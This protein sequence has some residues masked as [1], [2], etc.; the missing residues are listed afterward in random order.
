[1]IRFPN[2]ASARFGNLR[3]QMALR[4]RS[5]GCCSNIAAKFVQAKAIKLLCR[6]AINAAI[7]YLQQNLHL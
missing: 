5:F 1:M 4:Q 7:L 6:K 3:L 2:L